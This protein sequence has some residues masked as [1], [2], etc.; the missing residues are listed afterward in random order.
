M[1]FQNNSKISYTHIIIV[2]VI[3]PHDYVRNNVECIKTLSAIKT[4]FLLP[5]THLLQQYKGRNLQ[6]PAS[7]FLIGG[8]TK[9]QVKCFLKFF[10]F[11]TKW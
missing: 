1:K 10:W 3:E 9:R 6:Q 8:E 2:D 7:I 11:A 4:S 5:Q